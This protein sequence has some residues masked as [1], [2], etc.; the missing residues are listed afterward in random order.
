MATKTKYL[1][2]VRMDVEPA[3]EE[4][5]NKLYNKEHIPALLKAPG[6]LGATRY[7][8]SEKGMPKYLAIYEVEGPDVPNSDG[9][10]KASNSGEWPHKIRP[11]CTNRSHAM[12]K[13]ISM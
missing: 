2:V 13:Q 3:K 10:K 5:F 9:W 6:V 12:Y 4:L 7:E 8:T 11:Y 1:Y